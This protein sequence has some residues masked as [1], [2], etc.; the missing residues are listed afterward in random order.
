VLG[1]LVIAASLAGG[2]Y[3]AL[4]LGHER[5]DDAFVE[6]RVVSISPRVNGQVSAV[7]VVDN[8]EVKEGAA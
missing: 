8:Q 3:Y 5:T 1:A 7:K 4:G 2:G 6:G